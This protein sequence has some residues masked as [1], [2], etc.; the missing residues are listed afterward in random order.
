MAENARCIR[1]IYKFWEEVKIGPAIHVDINAPNVSVQTVMI[2]YHV[3]IIIDLDTIQLTT[4]AI[5]YS[6]TL[7]IICSFLISVDWKSQM[8]SSQ[9]IWNRFWCIIWLKFLKSIKLSSYLYVVARYL[10]TLPWIISPALAILLWSRSKSK[11]QQSKLTIHSFRALTIWLTWLTLK[12][13]NNHAILITSLSCL[14]QIIFLGHVHHAIPIAP[15]VLE[16]DQMNVLP[17][18]LHAYMK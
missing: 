8:I 13:I 10:T 15:N 16:L 18:I 6:Q 1:A 5:S 14:L 4:H 11:A 7:K 17:A 12:P 3:W 2:A 9:N